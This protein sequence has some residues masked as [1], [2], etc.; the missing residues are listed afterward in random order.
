[1][2]LGMFLI[3][4]A[5]DEAVID[6]RVQAGSQDVP[7]DAQMV[8]DLL[9]PVPAEADVP[10]HEQRPPLPDDL[11]CPGQRA[12]QRG[13]VRLSH[14]SCYPVSCIMLL[15]LVSLRVARCNSLSL[16]SWSPFVITSVVVSYQVKPEA[17]AEH[18]RLIEAVFDHLRAE[19]P[20]NIEYK[21]VR[22]ADGVS[23]VHLSSA[24]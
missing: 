21:V 17:M 18:V 22:L 24:E 10:Q 6:E 19:R 1:M 11:E 4:P 12:R 13:K 2:P 20:A 5:L 16:T 9:E 8:M 14:P 23:F 3:A 15:A 7:R